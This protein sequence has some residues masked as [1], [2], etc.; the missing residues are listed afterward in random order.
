MNMEVFIYLIEDTIVDE[1]SIFNV[2]FINMKS[3]SSPELVL[4]TIVNKR[5]VLVKL[6][7]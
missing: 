1:G 5:I 3:F 2:I 4:Q 7:K 6:G